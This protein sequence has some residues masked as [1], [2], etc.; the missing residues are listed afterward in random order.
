MLR[1]DSP[2][3]AATLCRIWPDPAALQQVDRLV[4]FPHSGDLVLLGTWYADGSVVGF[5]EHVA[6]H[7]GLGGPQ[8]YP[9]SSQRRAWIGT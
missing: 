9:F 2:Q 5:E 4:R 7:G 1:L 6:T 8:D 3:L